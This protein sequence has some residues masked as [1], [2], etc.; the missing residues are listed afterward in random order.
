M[1]GAAWQGSWPYPTPW[2]VKEGQAIK[3]PMLLGWG[4]QAG[5]KP[6]EEVSPRSAK[7]EIKL[8]CIEPHTQHGGM[9]AEEKK[10]PSSGALSCPR[11]GEDSQ[12]EE[13]ALAGQEGG[14]RSRSRNQT[15]GK[16]PCPCPC[17]PLPAKTPHPTSTPAGVQKGW[18]KTIPSTPPVAPREDQLFQRTQAGR[19]GKVPQ[20]PRKPRV[21]LLCPLPHSEEQRP[22]QHVGVGP[23]LGRTSLRE[24][25]E[26]SRGAQPTRP[27]WGETQQRHLTR[28]R[29]RSSEGDRCKPP[30]VALGKLWFILPRIYHSRWQIVNT[31]QFIR[32]HLVWASA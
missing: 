2:G 4:P 18:L 32:K 1:E 5:E 20:P 3:A 25:M 7:S 15:P 24:W 21:K 11:E 31:S 12:T 8:P 29:Q 23:R 17:L 14:T 28:G 26:C 13:W 16:S 6:G 27:A 10:L 30:S 19:G 22:S 9:W